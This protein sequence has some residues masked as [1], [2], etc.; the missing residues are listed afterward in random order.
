MSFLNRFSAFFLPLLFFIIGLATLYDYGM[1]WDSPIHFARGQAYLRYILTG[2]TNYNDLPSFCMNEGNLISRVDYKTGEICDRHRRVRVSEYESPLLD[3]NSWVAKSVYGHPSF[4]DIIL[5]ISN[6]IFFKYLGWVEDINAYHL[7]SLF[8]TFLLALTVSIWIKQTFGA[9]ASIIAVLTIYTFPLLAGE[10]HFNVKDPPMAAFFTIS[11]YLFW[12]S[13]VKKKA[14]YLVLSALAGGASFGTKFNFVFAPFILLPWIM[15]YGVMLLRTKTARSV[16]TK[17]MLFAASLYPA[18]VFLVFFLSWPALWENPLKNIP[19]VFRYYQDIGGSTCAYSRFTFLW[20][21]NCSQLTTLKYFIYTLPSFSLFLFAVGFIA[22]ITQFKKKGY[23][24]VLWLSF[25]IITLMRVTLP[26][27]NIYGGLRQIMEFV[28]PFA[29]I[30]GIG[31]LFLRD[32]ITKALVKLSSGKVLQRK[33]IVLG[34]SIL[35]G[36]GY[37]P[38]TIELV[39]LHPNENVYFNSFIG[40]LKGAAEKNFPGYGN[41]YGNA[42]LQGVKWLNQNAEPG[43][44]LALVSGLGQNLSRSQLRYDIDFANNYRSGYNQEGEYLMLLVT[45]NEAWTETF[46]HKYLSLLEPLYDLSVDSVSLLI[47]WKNDENF[48]KDGV[49]LDSQI[50]RGINIKF[51]KEES[52]KEIIIELNGS[53]NLKGLGLTFPSQEC[54]DS[55]IGTKIYISTNGSEYIQKAEGINNF[56]DREIL[57]YNA[58]FVYLFPGDKA[59]YIKVI[60]PES[61]SCELSTINF[62]VFTF[63]RFYDNLNQ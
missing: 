9:F 7:Y 50:E 12:L 49:N 43:A 17:K 27:S 36:L 40:G 20:L 55:M 56:T 44:K 46:R 62:S 34:V 45:G 8:T 22:S 10:Q 59:Q 19:Q 32:L 38:I 54:K 61:Y 39:R 53:K 51:A 28:G 5:A 13:I 25:F 31:T 26:V 11:L 1:N 58:D 14:L 29:M 3:F 63:A 42:Y 21:A 37:V 6:N 35:L 4:S 33:T 47:I 15:A 16:L 48:L 57:G 52:K 18:V 24:T 30:T 23:V 41:T 60:P 2:K